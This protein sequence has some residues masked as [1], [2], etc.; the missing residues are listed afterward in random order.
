MEYLYQAVVGIKWAKQSLAQVYCSS[1]PWTFEQLYTALHSSSLQEQEQKEGK[2]R[3]SEIEPKE[4]YAVIMFAGQGIYGNPRKYGSKS[5]LPYRHY[6]PQNGR[7]HNQS[8]LSIQPGKNGIDWYGNPRR[9][10]NCNSKDHLMRDCKRRGNVANN[11]IKMVR[12]NPNQ[13]NG[14]L[15]ELCQQVEDALYTT[16]SEDENQVVTEEKEVEEEV[17]VSNDDIPTNNF[18][19]FTNFTQADNG[20]DSVEPEDF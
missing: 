15:F 11:V 6:N 20:Y 5:S 19:L 3:D 14:I 18:Q 2:L 4:E 17:N 10:N 8:S 12:R 16:E 1:T 13:V 7:A 9:C